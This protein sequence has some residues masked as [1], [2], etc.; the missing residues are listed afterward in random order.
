MLQVAI[1]DD[2]RT[3]R[4]EIREMVLHGLFAHDEVAFDIYESG[5]Q[6][7]EEIE[8]KNFHSELLFLDIH[9]PE[10]D[11]LEVAAYIRER[12][13]DV[14]I[15]FVT[16]SAEHVFD[17]YT[18]NAF[19]YLLKPV[20]VRRMEEELGRYVTKKYAVSKCLHVIINNRQERIL[21]DQVYY[22][23][24]DGRKIRICQNGEEQSFYARMGELEEKLREQD[25]V[26]CHQSY[27]VNGKYVT[28]MAGSKLYLAGEELPVSRKYM[29]QTRQFVRQRMLRN[30][31]RD[32]INK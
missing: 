5:T 10:K 30:G 20:D 3:H 12:E 17:G 4:E 26:R 29:E 7:V 28:R 9:M 2:E 19:S 25:F 23:E 8:R 16:V 18:Y 32:G 11:G 14:D 15:F 13:L 1:C 31:E 21:L 6:L 27:L 22:F 24:G